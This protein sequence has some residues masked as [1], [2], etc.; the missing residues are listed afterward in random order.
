MKSVMTV[1]LV[2]LSLSITP[3]KAA[4]AEGNYAVWGVGKKSCFAY[5][6]ARMEKDYE[7]YT[8]YI[9]GFLTSYNMLADETYSIT[10]AKPFNELLVWLDDYCETKQIDALEQALLELIDAHHEKR[11]KAPRS[12]SGR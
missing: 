9:K 7:N 11:L 8:N 4:D 3:A 1:L 12:G 10:A 5:S 2:F 6:K